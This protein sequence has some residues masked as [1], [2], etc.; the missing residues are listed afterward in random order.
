MI[1]LVFLILF[2][3]I[4]GFVSYGAT[5]AYFQREWPTL[6]EIEKSNDR[7]FALFAFFLGPFSLIPGYFLSKRYKHGFKWR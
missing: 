2:W 5:F 7:D 3:I 1:V 6:A 4:C